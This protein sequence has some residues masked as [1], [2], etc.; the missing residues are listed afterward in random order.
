[1]VVTGRPLPDI[2][3]VFERLDP[4]SVDVGA[5]TTANP[6]IMNYIKRQ[7][8]LEDFQKHDEQTRETRESR[9]REHADGSYVY[10]HHVVHCGMVADIVRTKFPMGRVTARRSGKMFEYI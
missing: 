8:E 4:H 6:D 9:M 5:Q 2:Q 1:M 3:K 10:L 7:M